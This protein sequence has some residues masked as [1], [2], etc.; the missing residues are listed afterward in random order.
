MPLRPA[1]LV[2][3]TL[4]PLGAA[5]LFL[6]GELTHYKRALALAPGDTALRVVVLSA[7]LSKTLVALGVGIVPLLLGARAVPPR[8][9][10]GLSLSIAS[11]VLGLLGV[12]LEVQ[13]NTGNHV[14]DY[15]PYLIDPETFV[16]AGPGFDAAP[17]LRRVARGIVVAVG[18]ALAIAW[19]VERRLERASARLGWRVLAGLVAFALIASM[20]PLILPWSR[21]GMGTRQRLNER[22]PWAGL[23]GFAGLPA[24]SSDLSAAERVGRDRLARVWPRLVEPH[25][26][27]PLFER[28]STAPRPDILV[29]VVESLRADAL[30]EET[31]PRLWSWSERGL[32]QGEHSATSNASHYGLFALLYGR[33]PLFYF[34]TL[35]SG[36]R[37]TLPTQLAAWGY[38]RHHLGC[39]DLAWRGMDRFMGSVD[40]TVERLRGASLPDCDRAVVERAAA[41]LAPGA[42]APRFVLAFLMST[43]FG[44]HYPAEAERFRP[45]LAPPNALEL[46]PEQDRIGLVN[47]YRN[48]AH[49]ID[50]RI[51]ALLAR[52][53]P[54]E[55]LVVVTG[56]HGEA[57]FDDGTI[58]HSSR[59]SDAQTRVPFVLT[60]P[61]VPR[62]ARARNPSDHTDVLPTLLARLG[63][64]P[65][66]LRGLSGRDLVA[67]SPPVFVPLVAA[68]AR[69]GDEALVVLA[70][71]GLRY[72]WRLDPERVGLRFLGHFGRD[73]R[74]AEVPVSKREGDEAVDWLEDYL[75]SLAGR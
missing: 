7:L 42:R 73:G 68:R 20:A 6:P 50:D 54:D 10:R 25:S 45:A 46:D 74:P 57:L 36:E 1:P 13:H 75:E 49:A 16:W 71:D 30:D 21:G 34:E 5:I 9:L 33:S 58:A 66:D 61:G 12:D 40:F 64:A 2:F 31:M 69:R 47:R 55:T 67:A 22:M 63:V 24:E 60:G 11:I 72:A 41:L 26:P 43:H 62:G 32:R 17:G 35:D 4:L 65:D 8:T 27:R 39:S 53:D 70:S 51:G 19:L 14:L 29:V 18:P 23:A 38:E 37:P 48:S 15:L 3:A 56:D 59:L 52:V 44:Y 28:A